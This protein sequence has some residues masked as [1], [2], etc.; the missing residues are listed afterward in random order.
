M[1]V[2]HLKG[3]ASDKREGSKGCFRFYKW[4]EDCVFF[5]HLEGK[6]Q[7]KAGFNWNETNCSFYVT[8]RQQGAVQ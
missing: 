6:N 7:S 3:F 2:S 1:S 4:V 5:E 8:A